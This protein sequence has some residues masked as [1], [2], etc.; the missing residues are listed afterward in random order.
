MCTTIGIYLFGYA[1]RHASALFVAALEIF[2]GCGVIIPLL[3]FTERLS[4]TQIFAEPRQENWLWLG[5]A[6]VF[7]FVG[8]NLFS[9]I[10]LKS[11]G[12]RTSSLLSP[13]ITASTILLSVSGF[14]EPITSLKIAAFIVTLSAV[15]LFI[16]LRTKGQ[17]QKK[18]AT[19]LWS[20]AATVIC[21]TLSIICSVR[22]VIDTHLS[23]M[24]SVFL[25][26]IIALPLLSIAL[27]LAK[28]QK[29]FSFVS[30]L[31][32]YSAVAGGVI[33]QTVLA[34]YLWFYCTYNIGISTFQIIISTLP[35]FV[36]AMDVY[37]FKRTK[38]SPYFLL[39][40]F[41]AVVG[42]FIVLK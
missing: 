13:A 30:P 35:F 6:S 26:L 2:I 21:I 39:T 42:I 10:N 11:A 23:I 37:V 16:T 20:A 25:R 15:I 7:G 24:H 5:A 19:A 1:A 8:G 33:A 18:S 34:G 17:Q 38:A 40:A 3:L 29:L 4:L 14:N 27:L 28:V 22:G 41:I 36:Y 31:K 12:E 32:F 9:L